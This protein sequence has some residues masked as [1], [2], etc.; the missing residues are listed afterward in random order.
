MASIA[1]ANF[2]QAKR[3]ADRLLSISTDVRLRPIR[4]EDAEPSLHAALAAVVS[5]WEAYVEAIVIEALDIVARGA[6]PGELALVVLLKQEAVRAAEKFNTPNAENCRDLV[7][8]FTGLDAFPVLSS[9]RLGLAAHPAR[10][11]L[12]QIL[13]V[14]HSFAHGFPIPD[15]PW[16]IRAG[17]RQRLTKRAVLEASWL[18]EDLVLSLDVALGSHL[19][20]VFPTRSVW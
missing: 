10:E 5:A 16:T 13:K 1:F 19:R 6:T 12:N 14:R 2:D 8:R 17:V 20:A 3:R 18:I 7:L 4:Y 9:P 15:Y 11:R